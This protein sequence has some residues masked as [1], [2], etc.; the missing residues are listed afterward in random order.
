M[1]FAAI[2]RQECGWLDRKENPVGNLTS[3]LSGDVANV[4]N[5]CRDAIKNH[6]IDKENICMITRLL[7]SRLA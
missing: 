2:L 5:V 1:T 7:A 4:Q 3:C 6:L